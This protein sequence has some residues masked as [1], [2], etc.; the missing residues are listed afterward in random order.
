MKSV[1]TYIVPTLLLAM[2]GLF[3]TACSRSVE[4]S[5][6]YNPPA[7]E[8]QTV[9]HANNVL[10]DF[11]AKTGQTIPPAVLEHAAGVAIIPDITRAA[12]IAGARHGTGVL[13]SREGNQWSLPVFAS[14]T[15]GSLGLQVGVS[16]TDVVLVFQEPRII[17]NLQN[18]AN[19]T[20][21]SDLAVA[22]GPTGASA[23][24]TAYNAPVLA[25]RRTEGAF[26]GAALT[27]SRFSLDPDKTYAYYVGPQ[28]QTRG[29]YAENKNA[30][31]ADLLTPGKQA[32]IRNLPPNAVQLKRTLDRMTSPNR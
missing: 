25:Y 18:G 32:N 20:F 13:M 5:A 8:A 17:T 24:L 31:V 22:A 4:T 14:V 19:Y 29:Y 21:G 26:A 23:N 6:S 10:K 12:F 7:S 2:V 15:G 30:L 1:K 16:Q 11:V 9:D 28:S 27:G 3:Q